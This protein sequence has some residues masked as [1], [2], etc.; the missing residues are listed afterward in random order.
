MFKNDITIKY[1]ENC[2]SGNDKYKFDT[3]YSLESKFDK[4]SNLHSPMTYVGVKCGLVGVRVAVMAMARVRLIKLNYGI[5]QQNV[6]KM[7]LK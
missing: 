2:V 4:M 1:Y 5:F 6:V 3:E 7:S